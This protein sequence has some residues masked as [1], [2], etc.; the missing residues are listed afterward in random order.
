MRV[1]VWNTARGV[2]VRG[3][4]APMYFDL[5]SYLKDKPEYE[6]YMGQDLSG[7]LVS[8]RHDPFEP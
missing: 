2:R 1:S 5:A 8:R 6:V 3:G 4:N 7:G